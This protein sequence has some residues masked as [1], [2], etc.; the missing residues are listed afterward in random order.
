V[1]QT[2]HPGGRRGTA[3]LLEKASAV[4]NFLVERLLMLV[5]AA[6]CL[7]LFAQVVWRYAGYS[8]GWSEEVSRHLLVAITFLGST[9]AYRRAGFI[10]LRGVGQWF[11]PAVE[12]TILVL[13]QLL[14]LVCFAIIAW[15]GMVYTGKA[16]G[17]T[18]T[19]LQIPMAIPFV[20]IP[21]SAVILILHV[22][23]DIART[24]GRK[25]A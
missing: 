14:T 24:L 20:V 10:G 21:L 6:I 5:G 13:L 22:A 4:T 19:S 12:R 17:H 3:A 15:F 7:I 9:A 1:S 2:E 25:G 8:L 16:W 11:G 23:S 18:S